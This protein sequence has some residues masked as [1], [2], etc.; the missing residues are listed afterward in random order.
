MGH[1]LKLL[2]YIEELK[3]AKEKIQDN[4]QVISAN[5]SVVTD[6]NEY[7]DTNDNQVIADCDIRAQSYVSAIY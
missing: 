7:V 2:G 5:I 6:T 3:V 4:V 1:R